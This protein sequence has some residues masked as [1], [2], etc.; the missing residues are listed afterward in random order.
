MEQEINFEEIKV[1]GTKVSYYYV[2]HRKLWLF[3]R[4]ITMEDKSEK[5][6]LGSLLHKER[7]FAIIFIVNF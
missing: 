1:N 4:K 7:K 2:C 3:D 6:L 5:V